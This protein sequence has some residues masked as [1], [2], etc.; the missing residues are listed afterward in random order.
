MSEK[1]KPKAKKPSAHPEKNSAKPQK[2]DLP[3]IGKT[4][5]FLPPS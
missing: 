3:P 2:E 4:P 1:K 5:E